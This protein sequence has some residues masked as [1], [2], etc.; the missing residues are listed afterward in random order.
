L[1]VCDTT[2]ST[3]RNKPDWK[4]YT[5]YTRKDNSGNSVAANLKADNAANP[6]RPIVVVDTEH[7]QVY[8]FVSV[9]QGTAAQSSIRYKKAS[10]DAIN[11]PDDDG[12]PFITTDLL[13]LNP[14]S[15]I[16]DPTSTKQS[17]N[18]TTGLL[19]LAS[20]EVDLH[21]FHNFL[22]LK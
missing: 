6:T 16:N 13:N 14:N 5:V 15:V 12:V 18:S 19:V 11:F 4:H 10:I 1:L 17:V 22:S 3:C 9:E 8:V 2:A 20:D 21:Y 7:S